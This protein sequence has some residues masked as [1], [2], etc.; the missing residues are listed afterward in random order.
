MEYNERVLQVFRGFK[1]MHISIMRKVLYT[2]IT[3]FDASMKLVRLI[4]MYLDETYS[5]VCTG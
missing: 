2:I 3:E 4:E 1:K 5:K